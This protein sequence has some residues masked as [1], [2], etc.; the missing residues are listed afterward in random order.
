[1]ED[2]W[3]R[4]KGRIGSLKIFALFGIIA[5]FFGIGWSATEFSTAQSNPSEPQAVSLAQIVNGEVGRPHYVTVEGYA[6]H[7]IGYKETYY[8]IKTAECYYIFDE[9]EGYAVLIKADRM[10]LKKRVNGPIALTGL[11]ELIETY[12]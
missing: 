10:N 12:E 3:L 5:A 8:G 2:T 11:I 9:D 6:A 4:M 1:M 7:E